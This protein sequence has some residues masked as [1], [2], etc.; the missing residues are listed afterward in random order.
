[1]DKPEDG[2]VGKFDTPK[3][4]EA[5]TPRPRLVV[6]CKDKTEAEYPTAE[7]AA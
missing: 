5:V 7:P 3:G 1:M 6:L 4:E 2:G